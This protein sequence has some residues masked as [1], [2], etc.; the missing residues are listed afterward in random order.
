MAA[1]IPAQPTKDTRESLADEEG[2]T[3]PLPVPEAAGDPV[4]RLR[5]DG[6]APQIFMDL[7]GEIRPDQVVVLDASDPLADRLVAR[8]DFT[9]VDAPSA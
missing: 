6:H 9:E 8:G 7:G 4:R 2:L 3:G 5:Y 1:K